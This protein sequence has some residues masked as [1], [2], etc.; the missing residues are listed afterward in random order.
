MK[1]YKIARHTTRVLSQR[2]EDQ[3]KDGG[4]HV[5]GDLNQIVSH[6]HRQE[7]F[8]LIPRRM[9]GKGTSGCRRSIHPSS[10]H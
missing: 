7:S 10:G 8:H 4:S 2:D 6:C 9:K 5:P 1:T 3:G